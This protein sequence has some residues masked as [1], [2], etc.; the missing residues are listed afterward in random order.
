MND[1]GPSEQYR[2]SAASALDDLLRCYPEWATALGDHRFDD[3][4]DDLS[5]A[6]LAATARLLRQHRGTLASVDPTGLDGE[7]G[8][9][10]AMLTG[11]LDKKIFEIDELAC[12]RWDPLVYDPGEAFY[13]LL[14]RDVLPLPDRLRAIAARLEQVP[15]RLDLARRQL[16]APPKAHLQTAIDRHPGTVVMVKDEVERLLAGEPGLR[17][18]VEPAQRRALGALATHEVLLHELLEAPHHRSPRIGP[19]LFGRRLALALYSPLTAEEVVGRAER[20]VE[21][22]HAELAAAA[23]QFLDG[24]RAGLGGTEGARGTDEAAARGASPDD[25]VRSALGRIAAEGPDDS[26]IV[27][28]CEAA[29]VGCTEAVRA[30]GVV[31]LPDQPMRIELMPVFRRGAGGAYCDAAGPL[32]EGGETSFAIEPTPDGWAP[33]QKASFYREYNYAMVTNLTVHEAMPGHMVQLA[34]ARRFQ[35]TT[36]ARKILTSGT[37]VEGWAVHAERILAE[38]G[39]G[40]LP[41]RLQQLKMQLRVAINAILDAGVHA[42]ELT[43]GGALELMMGRGYQEE[44]EARSKWR[45]ACLTS[46]Q[47]ST[48]F[49]GYSELADL[50]A[51]LPATDN[52]NEVLA[53]GSPPPSLLGNLLLTRP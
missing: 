18:L 16:E 43:E 48:Y 35:G 2:R 29:L 40:G 9:D 21:E 31:T 34:H 41:V 52:Y 1:A 36:L 3:Q 7:D 12:A 37:F 5:E 13:P 24:A 53:H 15:G 26:T 23:A 45:R 33:E 8:V 39:H 14:T 27:A 22:L 32:E 6:A 4:L 44:S 47:L 38:H 25:I 42:G 11:E 28:A 10:L 49:V 51:E 20:R 46:S 17:P 50:F 30:Y 19:E